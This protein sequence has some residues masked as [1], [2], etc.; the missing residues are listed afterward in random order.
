MASFSSNTLDRTTSFSPDVLF[1]PLLKNKEYR[2]K[3]EY[4]ADNVIPLQLFFQ[5]NDRENTEDHQRDNF[6]NGFQLCRGELVVTN[7]IRW[8]LKAI[9]DKG[10]QPT[11]ENHFPQSRA[12]I[13]E[14]PI[15]SR[16]HEDIGDS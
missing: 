8:N 12:F 15:P 11:N 9:L 10:N 7:T 6:L 2:A 4:K 1:L 14:V 13:V 3:D 5:I 16:S